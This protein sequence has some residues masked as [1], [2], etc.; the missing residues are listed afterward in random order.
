MLLPLVPRDIAHL[1]PRLLILASWLASHWDPFELLG[2]D[3]GVDALHDVLALEFGEACDHREEQ[4]S[5]WST[6]INVAGGDCYR[7][8]SVPELF[9]ELEE[10]NG[11]TPQAVELPD[12]D[13]LIGILAYATHHLIELRTARLRPAYALVGED[14][15]RPALYLTILHTIPYLLLDGLLLRRDAAVDSGSQVFTF[16]SETLVLHLLQ[17]A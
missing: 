4:A 11:G 14:V 13:G 6:G 5:F 1:R 12:Y 10:V 17:G 9:K 2:L 8:V 15:I 3:A 16:L 7:D